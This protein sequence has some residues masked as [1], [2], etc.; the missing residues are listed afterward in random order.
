[1]VSCSSPSVRVHVAAEVMKALLVL[2]QFYLH[3][4]MIL[5]NGGVGAII[6]I[7]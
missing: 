3:A 1:M 7:T 5:E 2:L 6:E 4:E